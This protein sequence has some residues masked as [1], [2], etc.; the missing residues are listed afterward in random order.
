MDRLTGIAANLLTTLQTK[1]VE[2]LSVTTSP[3]EICLCIPSEKLEL[4]I[5]VL[6]EEFAL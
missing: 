1:D 3:I 2:P 5:S 6:K 4:A